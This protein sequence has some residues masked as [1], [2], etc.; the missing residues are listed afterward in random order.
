MNCR[1][2]HKNLIG[3]LE[4]AV[5]GDV[6]VQMDKHMESC[7]G[8]QKLLKEVSSTYGVW[9]AVPVP[10]L[11]PFFYTR[12]EQKYKTPLPSVTPLYWIW[13]L[14]GVAT[15]AL[16]VIGVGI[17]ITI[18]TSLSSQS[19]TETSL[20]RDEIIKAY[21]SD[22]YLSKTTADTYLVNE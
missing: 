11:N 1:L 16:M 8:C 17:G 12:V 18:G 7:A 19:T 9:D 2:F 21:A 6:H 4:K 13:K 14:R 22:Y 20:N 5:S 10:E 3:Y 15:V